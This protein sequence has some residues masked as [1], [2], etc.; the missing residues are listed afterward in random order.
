MELKQAEDWSSLQVVVPAWFKDAKFGLFFHWGPYS[1]PAYENEW[2]SRNMYEKG[3]KINRYHEATYGSVKKFGYKD[4]YDGL[5]GAR[6]DPEEWAELVERS[7]AK[8]GG[9]VTEHADNFSMWNSQVNPV[10]CVNYG[11]KRDIT[12]ECAAAFRRHH[13]KFLATFHHQWL[14]GWFMST[15]DGAD[16]Y[17]PANE[18]YYSEAQPL[19][20][21][22]Y[23]PYRLPNEKF[24]QTW[25]AKIK[26]VID[27]YHPDV[28]YFDSRTNIIAEKTRLAMVQYYQK[29]CPDGIITYKQEDLPAGVG[30]YDIESGRFSEGQDFFW[31]TDDRIENQVTWCMVQDPKYKTAQELVAHLCDVVAKNGNLLLNVGPYADGSFHPAAKRTLYALGDWLKVNGEGIYETRPFKVAAEGPTIVQDEQYDVAKIENQIE[32]GEMI[33][34]EHRSLTAQDFR[35]TRKGDSVYALSMG[36]PENGQ[37]R[38]KSLGQK[39]FS[40]VIQKVS[41]LGSKDQ[42]NF[43]QTAQELV[44]ESPEIP[45]CDYAYTLKI[46][47]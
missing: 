25:L 21:R 31:Q 3:S 36:W 11:P 45:P 1:V 28:L 26:E 9:P 2:Y 32:T 19:E 4:F 39:S 13:L 27:L 18:K 12:G 10:N 20:T 16:V 41:L 24:C 44:I 38:I 8:Y 42:L 22:R 5:T 23:A 46:E 37:W 43:Q 29:N 30:V 17:D 6:F 35:F 14:W 47:C 40:K 15:I 7:G 34:N 33:T